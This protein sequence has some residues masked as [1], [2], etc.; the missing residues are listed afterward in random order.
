MEEARA[1]LE[2]ALHDAHAAALAQA[3][4]DRLFAQD[5]LV[6][7]AFLALVLGV[8]V[9][10]LIGRSITRPLTAITTAMQRLANN[11]LTVEV[12][13]RARRD[14]IG[15]IA[16]TVEV[17]KENSQKIET[18][19]AE[20]EAQHRRNARRVT[21]EMFAL[22]NALDEEVRAAIG[23]VQQQSKV[24]HDAAVEMTQAVGQ[25]EHGADAASG[26][27]QDSASSVEAV[28]AAAEEMASSIAE[29]SRQVNGA[30]DIAH[31]AAREAESTNDRIQGLANA[32]SQIGEVVDLISDIAKQTNLLAL[33]ATIE[34]ARAGDAGK[35]F[36]VVA[37]E[38]KTLA[39][40]TAKATEDIASQIG[41]IQGAT[42]DAVA[43]IKGIVGVIDEIN[44]ITTAVSAAVEEQSAATGEISQ[45][46]QQAAH[47][48]QDASRNIEDLSQ[49]TEVTGRHA[50][51]VQQSA[52]EVHQRVEHMLNEL[53]AIIQAGSAAERESHALRP[54]D[55]TV[56][57][58]LG[59]GTERTCTLHRMAYS[60]VATIDR[61]VEGTRGQAITLR[62]PDMGEGDA[63]AANIVARTDTTT[64]I[65]IDATDEQM[66]ALEAFVRARQARA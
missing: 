19:Q 47:S 41:G 28:A 62:L 24:M 37:N 33:N 31:R 11:D 1:A 53:E 3:D 49:S 15:A 23:I 20:Q 46:A 42:N 34:A 27:S 30:S 60:G 50:R 43:A 8:G 14:E 51:E 45:N 59:D 17:F 63:L 52:E 38:V 36:A 22:T 64:H 35:G 25:T 21:S 48:T 29:I 7:G 56:T 58:D 10:L 6:W 44:Q 5:L 61:S 4:A 18:M 32:A 16:T 39:N 2:D 12:P 66:Q 57:V 55:M 54:I 13:G 40:Q 26:A 65:R 9:A